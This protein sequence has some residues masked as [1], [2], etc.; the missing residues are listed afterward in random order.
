MRPELERNYGNPFPIETAYL[1][2]EGAASAGVIAEV[3]RSLFETAVAYEESFTVYGDRASFIW[4]N[5]LLGERHAVIRLADEPGAEQEGRPVE[6]EHPDIPWRADKLPPE[7]AEFA[8][9]LHGGA[10]PHLVHE[11]VRSSIEGRLSAIDVRRAADWT[12]PG[13]VAHESALRSGIELEVPRFA[14]AA[15]HAP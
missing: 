9:D 2:L 14:D 13:L 1:R 11:F 5:P 6:V 3:T 8:E 12:A 7:L 15:T 10:E 4:G